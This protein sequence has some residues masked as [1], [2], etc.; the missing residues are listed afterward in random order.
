MGFL[1][2]FLA[3]APSKP[4]SQ[5]LAGTHRLEGFVPTFDNPESARWFR[6]HGLTERYSLLTA[7]RCGE[8]VLALGL[9]GFLSPLHYKYSIPLTKCQAFFQKIFEFWEIIFF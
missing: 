7:N 8:R 6:F 2:F 5:F 9:G 3:T 1:K 4:L